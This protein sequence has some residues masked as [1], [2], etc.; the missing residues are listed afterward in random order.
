MDLRRYELR[1]SGRSIRLERQPMELLILLV[2]KQGELVTREAIV[3]RL[4]GDH[5]FLDTERSINSAIRKIRVVLHDDPD[6]PRYLET[7]VGKGYRFVGPIQVTQ[8]EPAEALTVP[9]LKDSPD[10]QAGDATLAARSQFRRHW[11]VALTATFVI[12]AVVAAF[13]ARDRLNRGAAPRMHSLAVLPLE[14]LSGDPAQE[15]FADG[16]T[17]ELVTDLALVKSLHV[18]S[19]TSVMQYKG[20]RKSLSQIGHE[21]NVDAIVEGSVMRSGDRVRITAQLIETASDHHLWA[22]SFE[23]DSRDV[24][25]LQR[26]IAQNIANRVQAVLTPQ[27]QAR[28]TRPRLSNPE[29]YEAYLKGRY[30]WNNRTEDGFK[31][32]L[33]FFQ[34]AIQ[35]DPDEPLA[36]AGLADSYSMLA[37]YFMLTPREAF[38]KAEA[39]AQKSLALDESLA[40]AHTSLAYARFHYDYDWPSAEHEFKRAIDLNPN[41]ATAHQWYAEFLAAMGRSDQALSEI[42]L[43][44]QLDPFSLVINSNVGRMLYL[45]RRYDE[46]IQELGNTIELNPKQGYAHLNLGFAYEEKK[47][48]AEAEREFIAAE[49]LFRI[50]QS[51]ARAHLYAVSGRRRDAALM[52]KKLEQPTPDNPFFLAGVHAALGERDSAFRLLDAA[53]REH[54]FFLCFLRVYPWMDS[55]RDD[56]RFK[57]LLLRMKLN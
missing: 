48:Y 22:Q 21:L 23:R 7:V 32:A 47:M 42:R 8:R 2:E 36:Y 38:P 24:L 35:K 14:N 34:F 27:E 29:A 45:A 40:E 28:L 37:N 39:A 20:T 50:Q 25:S 3:S 56:P 13:M 5:T 51:I 52:L 46:A 18:I 15:Y 44:Q 10:A 41:Y 43:A 26:E 31:K 4:W 12:A 33:D 1:R 55:L 53:Y 9:V 49:S 54:D 6:D 30:Y 11:H 16:M 17:D 57:E 19:R